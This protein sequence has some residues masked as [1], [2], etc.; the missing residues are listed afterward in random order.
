[1]T[2]SRVI[3]VCLDKNYESS[4]VILKE[5]MEYH[6]RADDV[7]ILLSVFDFTCIEAPMIYNADE[8]AVNV[9]RWNTCVK[10]VHEAILKN[11]T[12]CRTYLARYGVPANKIDTFFKECNDGIGEVI[13]SAAKELKP[14][15]VFMGKHMKGVIDRAFTGSNSTYV[16]HHNT[17]PTILVTVQ[18]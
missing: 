16:V 5:F 15:L 9:E 14:T 3:L 12:E 2:D 10:E 6:Y 18:K 11:L 7:I 1:M 13:C 17:V 8:M 4:K